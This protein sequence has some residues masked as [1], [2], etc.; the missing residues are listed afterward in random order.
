MKNPPWAPLLQFISQHALCRCCRRREDEAEAEKPH[1]K[2][3]CTASFCSCR[4]VIVSK[5]EERTTYPLRGWLKKNKKPS[6]L[7]YN[8]CWTVSCAARPAVCCTNM[9]VSDTNSHTLMI[10]IINNF[11]LIPFLCCCWVKT[12][13]PFHR[14]LMWQ[15]CLSLCTLVNNTISLLLQH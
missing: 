9:K 12:N 11:T 13:K 5:E 6:Y 7:L 3:I 14:L 4:F 2:K 10:N 1:F 15:W 8:S